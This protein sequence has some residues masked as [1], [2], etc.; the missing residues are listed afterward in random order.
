MKKDD[1]YEK[2]ILKDLDVVGKG[3]SCV[4]LGSGARG[5]CNPA[6]ASAGG[7]CNPSGSDPMGL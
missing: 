7:A 1:R 5:A 6:G 4:P 3:D 2:P